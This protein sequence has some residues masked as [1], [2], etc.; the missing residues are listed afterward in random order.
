MVVPVEK[1]EGFEAAR[2]AV[3][4]VHNCEY[5]L[6]QRPDEAIHPGYD[7][8]TEAD[9][10]G[11]DNFLSNYEPLTRSDAREMIEDAIGFDRFTPP[12]QRL[13]EEMA[14]DGS[15]YFV[16]S[17]RPRIVDG[18]PSKNPRYLQ[19][20]AALLQPRD[21]YL[22][23][24]ATRMQRRLP[25][26]APVYTPVD[27]VLPGR[28][29]NPPEPE[30]NIPPLAV[31]NPIH[32]MPL[33]EL[34]IEFI[35]S[36]TGKSPSTTGA[37]SEG[38]LTKGPFNALHPIRDLNIALLSYLLTGYEAFITAAGYVGPKVRV[39][40]DISLLVPEL[41]S[42]MSPE[43][44]DPRFLIQKGYLEKCED[45]EHEG[46][47]VRASLLGYRMT[48][49]FIGVFFGRI[50]NHPNAV[51][52]EAM[53]RPELQ[54][55]STFADAMETIVATQKRVSQHYFDDG[56][57][58]DACPPLKALLH[59]MRHDEYEGKGLDHD[60]IRAL[61]TRENMLASEWYKDFTRHRQE[62]EV[63]LWRRHVWYLENF[64]NKPDYVE[65][66]TRLGL[67]ERLTQAKAMLERVQGE[68]Y[69]RE[70]YGANVPR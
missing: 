10:A 56:G 30:N 63:S 4:F 43:E 67:Q 54:D 5:R 28:R 62:N 50:F 65:E 38:A 44:R 39:D 1:L 45:F 6:F 31:F 2:P 8:Q 27:A 59:I 48:R 34:F 70:R 17:A 23:E 33:P 20:R 46:R 21:T 49:R 3:K 52:S 58:E 42:R 9:I 57:I 66:A 24:M 53:L 35:C 61:F 13:I 68:E 36:M 41:W 51:C 55:K 69:L 22:C 32:Y 15:K 11:P 64:L 16:C 26:S 47:T 7:H 29:N 12:M 37:G 25:L 19:T 18:K 60:D 40:H 14:S